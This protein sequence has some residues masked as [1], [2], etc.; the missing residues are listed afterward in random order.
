MVPDHWSNNAM[1]SMDRCG[2]DL[3]VHEPQSEPVQCD[4]VGNFVGRILGP[5]KLYFYLCLYSVF[6]FG[7]REGI[8]LWNLG[9][10]QVVS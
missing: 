2:L 1:V 4:F 10:L 7:G 8:S 5:N 9:S 6:V 3:S